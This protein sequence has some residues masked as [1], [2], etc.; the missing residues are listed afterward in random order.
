MSCIWF[1]IYSLHISHNFVVQKPNRKVN[2]L[3]KPWQSRAVDSYL[4][5]QFHWNVHIL[6]S[7]KNWYR[8]YRKNSFWLDHLKDVTL[9][10]ISAENYYHFLISPTIIYIFCQLSLMLMLKLQEPCFSA[11][12]NKFCCSRSI[13][14]V[15]SSNGFRALCDVIPVII[16]IYTRKKVAS[17]RPK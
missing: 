17:D 10:I 8:D 11:K 12:E 4:L 5:A 3:M 16:K 13:T 6:V 7:I 15:V 1:T 9:N 2:E 14:A